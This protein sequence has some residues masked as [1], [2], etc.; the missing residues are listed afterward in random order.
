MFLCGAMSLSLC[1]H[2]A[3]E[4][5]NWAWWVSADLCGSKCRE[6]LKIS[7]VDGFGEGG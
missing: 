7:C 5:S 3:F 4:S 2:V 1:I 6:G